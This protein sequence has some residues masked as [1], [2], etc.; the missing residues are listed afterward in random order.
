M[1]KQPLFFGIS[2][3]LLLVFVGFLLQRIYFLQRASRTVGTVS[4]IS[5]V[6]SS[7]GGG[8][9]R[10]SYPCT[11][12]TATV[13]FV[14]RNTMSYALNLSAGSARGSNQS[15]LSASYR[16]GQN[17]KVIYNPKDPSTAYE[18]SLMGVWGTP[19]M[20]LF[21]QLL[22]GISS[23]FEPRKKWYS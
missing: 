22:T 8:R 14:A 21:M 13:K 4:S 10:S 18:D 20:V 23:L 7:C 15:N 11:K 2:G 19:F 6:N 12:F 1:I 16:S 17:V 5:S 3:L 9:R